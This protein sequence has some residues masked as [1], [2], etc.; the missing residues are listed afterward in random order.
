M[1]GGAYGSE[2]KDVFVS[3]RA[4]DNHGEIHQLAAEDMGFGYR[5]SVILEDWLFIEGVLKGFPED[6]SIIAHRMGKIKKT[7][8]KSQPVRTPTGGSTFTNPSDVK[9]WELIDAAGCRGMVRGGAM[10]SEKH[11]NF[12]INKGD[13]V[14]ADLEGLGEEVRRRVYEKSGIT[15][16]WEIQRIGIPIQGLLAEGKS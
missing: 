4:V 2:F 13:A 8:E 16:E 11:C 5:R 15:L 9:A 6:K 10:V 14:A 1:N 12:L 3:A 7:R